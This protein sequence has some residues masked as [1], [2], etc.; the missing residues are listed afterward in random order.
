[1]AVVWTW[2]LRLEG[3]VRREEMRRQPDKE[4]WKKRGERGER[5][6]ESR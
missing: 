2:G 1:V 3:E 4:G 5:E 6:R